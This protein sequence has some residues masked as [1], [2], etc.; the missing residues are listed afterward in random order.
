MKK[1]MN[2][3]LIAILIVIFATVSCGKT[4]K[5][6]AYPAGDPDEV[7][8]VILHTN[9]VHV[10]LQDN[11]GYDGLALYKKEVEAQYDNV[12]LVDAGDAIQGAAIGAISKG[13]E[14]IKIMNRLGYDLAIPGNHEFD[15]GFDVLDDCAETL[16]CGYTCANFCTIDGEP[17]FEPWRILEAGDLKIGFVGAVT[18]DT[19]TRSAIKDIVNEVGEPMYD[20]L[21]DETGD[22][23]AEAL[24]KSIDE[25]DYVILVAHLGS[26][27]SNTAIYSSNAIVGKLTGL[28]V[29]IDGHSHETYETSIPDKDG[30]PVPIAQTGTKLADIGQLTIY[31]DGRLE[32][33]L[34]DT[35]PHGLGLPEEAVTRKNVERY[36]DPDMKAFIDEIAASY[37]SLMSRKIGDLSADLMKTDGDG[38]DMSRLEENGLCDL[39][40]DAFRGVCGTQTALIGAG[41]VR[42]NLEAG[43]VTYKDV[44][45]ILPYCNEVIM[46]EVSGRMLLDALEF[47]VSFLP[48]RSGAFPQVSGITFRVNKDIESSVRLDEKKQFISVD[49]EYRVSDVKIDGKDLDPDAIYTLAITSYLFT[50]GDGY[51]MFGDGNIY[52]STMLPDNEVVM[53]YIEEDLSGVI[54]EKYSEPQG[55][56]LWAE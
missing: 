23:L 53:K 52:G 31:K 14:I 55:R 17:V 11:I 18:P 29:V 2:T 45:D 3:A 50:G 38:K 49:G 42:T 39:V 34:V 1:R 46:T 12:L 43:E 8:A 41:S 47:G 44:V 5:E 9:D 27:A 13:S 4:A 26:S 54:P 35:V 32:G 19:Y 30:K 51:T 28:D 56:I 40:A 24:Q 10:G 16:A 7:A 21:A 15:F 6:P 25:A 33:T 37:D 20:F 36:V 48:N 22:R